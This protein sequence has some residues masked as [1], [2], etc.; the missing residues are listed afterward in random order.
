V[1]DAGLVGFEASVF[2]LPLPQPAASITAATMAHKTGA[3]KLTLNVLFMV[4]SKAKLEVMEASTLL[5]S[6]MHLFAVGKLRNTL[7]RTG[8]QLQGELLERFLQQLCRYGNS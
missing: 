2:L 7:T 1:G 5:A 4:T 8:P 3:F 6:G